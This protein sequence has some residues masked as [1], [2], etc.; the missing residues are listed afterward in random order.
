MFLLVISLIEYFV[1]TFGQSEVVILFQEL[2]VEAKGLGY[3]FEKLQ[4][5]VSYVVLK[6]QHSADDRKVRDTQK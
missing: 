3:C 6:H 4:L 1:D 2:M 5:E